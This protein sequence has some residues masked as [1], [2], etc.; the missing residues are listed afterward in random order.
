M[1]NSDGFHETASAEGMRET[2]SDGLRQRLGPSVPVE[3]YAQDGPK[4]AKDRP[5]T[6]PRWPKTGTKQT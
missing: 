6:G 1:G 5:K 3:K 4:M 2:L